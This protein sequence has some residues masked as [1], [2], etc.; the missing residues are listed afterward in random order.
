MKLLITLSIA[1]SV[2]FTSC[3]TNIGT[4]LFTGSTLGAGIGGIAA[5]KTGALIAGAAGILAGTGIGISL[6]AQDRKIMQQ[7]SPRTIERI[8]NNEPLTI[9]DVI[10]LS[11]NGVHENIILQYM[12]MQETAYHLT[13]TQVRRLEAAKVSKKIIDYMLSTL[14]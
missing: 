10:K 4:G 2:F 13:Q 5:G 11:E 7:K 6:D 12:Q 14:P 8:D 3:T 9:N 1:F